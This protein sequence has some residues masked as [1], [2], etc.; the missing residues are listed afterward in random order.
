MKPFHDLGPTGAKTEDEAPTGKIVKRQCGHGGHGRRTRGDLHNARAQLNAFRMRCEI[1][2]G[3]DR[4]APPGLRCKGGRNAQAL[5]KRDPVSE[6]T[7]LPRLHSWYF[8]GNPH[9]L[10]QA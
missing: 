8:D 5:R 10:P 2:Q 6:Q 1:G 7:K 4:I 3:R 9:A